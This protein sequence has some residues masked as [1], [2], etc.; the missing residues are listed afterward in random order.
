MRQTV[1]ING[2]LTTMN[3]EQPTASAFS[4]C[5]GKF[6]SIGDREKVLAEAGPE[7]EIVD[8]EGRV[9]LPGF[10]ETHNHMSYYALTRLMVDCTPFANK[11]IADVKEKLAAALAAGGNTELIMGWG[12][13]DTMMTDRRHLN[14]RDLDG[15]VSDIPVF[16][17]HASG[18]LAYV[19]SAALAMGNITKDTP[20]PAGGEIHRDETGE[21]TGLLLEPSAIELVGA[22]LP[23]PDT[24]TFMT[25]L[26][27]AMAAYNRTGVTSTHDAAIGIAGQ[28]PG[29]IEAYRALEKSGRLTVRT[30]LTVLFD[31]YDSFIEKGI[32]NG[33]GSDDLRFGSVKLFQDG[34]IQGLTA[35]LKEDYHN[36]PG[37]RGELI[38]PQEELDR[39]VAKYHC[40]GMQI[41]VHA[42]G[43]RAIE[44]V[45]TAFERANEIREDTSLRHMLIHCQMASSGH[46]MR[47]KKLGIIPSYFINHL[48][49]WGDRHDSIFI[50]PERAARMNPLGESLR[51]GLTFTLHADTP[52]LPVS[53][54]E[55]IH[56]AVNRKTRNGKILGEDQVISPMD[57][58]KTF[59]TDAA[60]CSFEEDKKGAIASGMLADFVVL[61]DNPLTVPAGRIR[62][63]E[64]LETVVGGKTVYKKDQP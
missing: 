54:L 58:L 60:K 18:H 7:P 37:H 11:S 36:R 63:I 41:A 26:P 12:F 56:N 28:G 39:L 59:T 31:Y 23:S 57:A 20:D 35:A 53:P 27:Q 44:S 4:V 14:R 24:G 22:H 17:F 16:I 5:H 21:P 2:D 29:S 64:V 38:M 50:G 40:L 34:S 43:D 48:F 25:A 46:I 42:N 9:V 32:R 19:N 61:S 15:I 45:I 33:F 10:I 52:V 3:P 8:L 13:D 62:D 6:N 51:E 55:C 1:Y 49:H 30:Y 47:M